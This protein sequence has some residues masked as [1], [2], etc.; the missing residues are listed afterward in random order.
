[1]LQHRTE[2][3]TGMLGE[4]VIQRF[5]VPETEVERGVLALSLDVLEFVAFPRLSGLVE[6]R[7]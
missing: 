3:G 6:R 2:D 1:M 4:R 5:F 7:G